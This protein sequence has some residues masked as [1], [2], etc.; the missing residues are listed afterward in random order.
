MRNGLGRELGNGIEKGGAEGRKAK[1]EVPAS[2]RR[3]NS[4]RAAVKLLL[5]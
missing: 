3:M 1:M 2:A 5:H 4:K